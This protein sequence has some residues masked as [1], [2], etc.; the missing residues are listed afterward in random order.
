[1]RSPIGLAGAL[2]L[3]MSTGMNAFAFNTVQGDS[4]IIHACI[5]ASGHQRIDG[6]WTTCRPGEKA[7]FWAIKS[8]HGLTGPAGPQ[9]AAG[10]DGTNGIDG[11]D[12]ADGLDGADGANGLDGVDGV[13]GAPGLD[14]TNGV[15]GLDGAPGPTGPPGADGAPGPSGPPGPTG[16]PGADGVGTALYYGSFYDTTTQTT[17]ADTATAMTLNTTDVSNGVSVVGG[18]QITFAHAG[19]YNVQ[20]SAQLDKTGSNTEDIDIWLRQNGTNVPWSNTALAVAGSARYVAAWNFIVTVADGG[21]VELMW[22]SPAASMELVSAPA[23][24]TPTRP[25]VPSVI[26]TA[27]RVG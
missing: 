18:S 8:K 21:N 13:D 22:S 7:L 1:M 4:G 24:V 12:G 16:A 26:V 20:F 25:E 10:V 5:P 3:V 27:T 14:G 11:V 9:G 6:G 23:A 15:D 2:V 19:V 17:T